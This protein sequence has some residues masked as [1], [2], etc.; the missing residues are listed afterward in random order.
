[1]VEAINP[2]IFT[3]RNLQVYENVPFD[4]YLQINGTSYSSIKGFCGEISEGMKLGS[5]VHAFLGEPHEY[6][7]QDY[8]TV[9]TIAGEIKKRIGPAFKYLAKEVCFTAEFHYHGFMMRFKGRVDA[10]EFQKI[11][12]DYKILSGGVDSAI[13][14]FGYDRQMSGYC[15]ATNTPMALIIAWNKSKKRIEPKTI[16]PDYRWWA[17]KVLTHGYPYKLQ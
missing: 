10:G 2:D 15:L 4:E 1:M 8:S 17:E 6:D 13:Q 12:L 11:I 16:K 3:V 5:R 9:K 7:W 14:M